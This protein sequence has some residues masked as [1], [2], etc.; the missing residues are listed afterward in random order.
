M[1]TEYSAE[2]AQAHL[3]ELVRVASKKAAVIKIAGQDDAPAAYIVPESYWQAIQTT[4]TLTNAGR[5]V[6]NN[7]D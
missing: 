4:L 5:V 6:P 3:A 1:Q 7:E 2:M